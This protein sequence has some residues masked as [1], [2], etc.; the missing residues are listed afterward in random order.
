MKT[1]VECCSLIT[2]NDTAAAV[3]GLFVPTR[4]YQ[5]R[6]PYRIYYTW[7][8]CKVSRERLKRETFRIIHFKSRSKH[9]HQIWC[10][11]VIQLRN[12]IGLWIS[13]WWPWFYLVMFIWCRNCVSWQGLIMII[14]T[15]LV[16]CIFDEH[17]S[18]CNDVMLWNLT[19]E[20]RGVQMLHPTLGFSGI[21]QWPD[22]IFWCAIK[23]SKSQ[24]QCG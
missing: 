3:R 16:W 21:T 19:L 8:C 14:P 13:K 22:W 7:T 15:K 1:V 24:Y 17:Y 4:V 18:T 6:I 23:H 9:F 2:I 11:S 20:R 12:D 5:A 10:R